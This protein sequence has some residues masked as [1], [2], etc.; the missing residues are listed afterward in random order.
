MLFSELMAAL[1]TRAIR[2]QR[3]AADL[4][5]D[6]ADDALDD[7][8][9]D[10]LAAHKPALLEMLAEQGGEWLSPALR[11]TPDMLP[12]VSLDQAAIDRIVASVPGGVA[13]VQ[14][15]YPLAPMQEGMLYHHLSAATG[16]PY[17][18]Q[19]QLRFADPARLEAFAEALDWV[20]QR[21]DIL[22]TAMRWE[23]LDAPVQVV[24]R[25]APLAR[26]CLQ[27]APGEDALACLRARFDSRHYRMDLGQAPLLRL[28]H[29]RGEGEQ[30]VALLLF[31]HTVMDHTGLDIVRREIQAHLTGEGEW[32]PAPVPFRDLLAESRMALDEQAHE[33]FFADMLAD[34]DEPTL[35]F[36]VQEVADAPVEEARLTLDPALS[37]R[38]RAQ[39]RTLGVSPASIMHLGLA[40]LLGALSG[41]DAVVF[42]SVLLGRMAAGEGGE[43]ALGMFINTLPLRVD[44]AGQGVRDGL[45]ATHRQLTAL[46]GHEQAPLALAQRCSGVTAPTPLFNSMLNYRHSA[47]GDAAEVIPVAPGIDVIGAEERTNYP[48][49]L[50]VDDL[51]EDLRLT[52]QALASWGAER[53]CAQLGQVFGELVEALEQQP[54]R[55]LL[56]LAVLTGEE[57]QHLLEAC[58]ASAVAHDLD[59]PLHALFEQQVREQGDA[60]ALSFD[61]GELSYR[62]LDQQA[63][64][65][66]HHLVGLGVGPDLR[67]A[68]CVER[69]PA[70][71]VGLLAILKAGGAYVPVDPSYPVERIRH[72]LADSAPLAVLV[73]AATRHVV[74]DGA[75]PLIDLDQPSWTTQPADAPPV[76]GLT[77]RHLAYVIYTSGSTGL[78]KGVMVE[79]RNVVNLVRWS[80]RLWPAS[81]EGALLH[82]TPIS[83]DA[84]VWELFW[85]LCSGLRLVL[86]RPDGQRDPQYLAELIQHE[87]VSV[88]QFVPALLQQFLEQPDSARCSSLTDIVCGGGELTEALARQVR[89]RLPQARLHNVYGPTETTVDCS[90]FT[91]DPQD[92]LPQG[93][94]PIGRP[95][96]NTRLYVLD[97]ADQPLPWGVAGHLHIGGAGVARGYLGLAQQQAERFIDSPFVKG[98]RLYRSGDLVRQRADGSL[99]FLGRN[100][101]QIKLRGLRIE[102]G[103]IE[104]AL[105]RVP[106]VR[107]TV[108]LVHEHA[109]SGPRLVAWYSGVAQAPEQLR[110][111][112]LAQLPEYMVPAL[113]VH[114]EV[115]PLTPN[116]KLDRKAL[117]S[118]ELPQRRHEAPQGA[119]EQALATIWSDLLGVAQVGRH[120]NFFELGGHSLLAVRLVERMRQQGLAADVR[121]LFGQPTLAALAATVGG[122]GG[123]SVPANRITAGCTHITPD[124]LP[125]AS[126]DQAAL[127]SVLAQIPGGAA[128]VQDLYA[129]APLQQGILYHHLA[130]EGADPYVVQARFA[131][132]GD[133]ELEAFVAAL[134]QVIARHDILRTSLHWQGLEE[135]VQVVWREAPLQLSP[136]LEVARL[137]LGQ[138][139]LMRLSSHREDGR[140]QATLLLHHILL[141]HTAVEQLVAEV[142]ALL[143]GERELPP[144]V[145]YR[146]YVAQA[147]LG[148]DVEADEA[149]FREL[150]GDIDEPTEVFGL[151]EAKVEAAAVRDSRLPLDSALAA[152]LRE[153]ARVLGISVASLV[154]QAWG[155]V[156]AQLSG[157]EEVVFGTV[158]LGRLQGGE[159]AD[160]ALGMFINTLPLRVSVGAAGVADGV[161]LTHQRLARLLAHEQASL[162]LAQRCSGV[163]ASQA[164]FTSLLN[165]RHSTSSDAHGPAWNGIELLAAEER[166]NYPLV[167]SVDDYGSDFRLTV[168]ATVAVEGGQV[169][170]L[171]ATALEHL[172]AALEQ[173]PAKALH[174]LSGL[175]AAE[176]ERVLQ[177]FNATARDYPRE[178][179][180]HALFEAH[181]QRAPEA[182]AVVHGQRR[183]SYAELEAQANRLAHHLIGL[184]VQPADR[185]ALLLPR[186]F[187]LLSAQLAVSKCAAVFVPL[188]ANAPAE[189]Q[190]FMVGDSQAK[191]LLTHSDQ[192]HLDGARR[193]ELDLLDLGGHAAEDLGLAVD[194]GCAAYIMYTS[195]STGTPKGVQVPHRAIVRL[196][197][198][199]GFA[200]FNSQDRV[201]FASN[202]AFDASTLEVW[203]PLLNGG[204]VVVIDQDQVLSRQALREVLLAQGVTVLWLTAGLF[205]QFADDLLPAFR[206]LRYLMVGG[207]VLDP[208]VIARVLRNGAPQH[209]LNGYGPTEATTFSTTHEITQVGEG[210]IPIGRPIGNGR[211]YVLDARQQLLPVGAVGELYIAGDGVALGYLGQPELTAER[212]LADPFNGGTMYRS[213][214]LVCWQADGTL[215]YLGRADQQIKLRGFRIELGEI[216]ARLGECAGV[217]DTAVVVREDAPGDKRLVAYFTTNGV[218]PAIAELH[219]RLQGQLPDYMLPAAYVQLEALPLTAN[220]KLDRRALPQPGSDAV[221]SRTFEAP[222]G[223]IEVA[224]AALWAEVLKVEQVGRHDHFFELGGHSLLA[225][226]LIERMRKAGLNADV[227]VLFAQPTLAALAAAVG[228]G[229]EIEVPANRVPGNAT[230]ITPDMLSLIALDQASIDRIVATVPGGAANVQEIYPLAPLQQGILYHHLSADEGDPYLLQSRLAFDSLERL[231]AWAGALQ[232]V[233]DRHDILRTAVLWEGL[234]EP[235]QVVW[236]QARLSLSEVADLGEDAVLERLQARFDARHQ[237]LDLTQAPLLRLV[238]ARDPRQGEYVALLQ[239]HHLTL[240]HAAMAVIGEEMQALLDGHAAQLPAAVPYRNYVAQVCLGDAQAAHE[241]FFRQQLGDVEAPTLPYGLA[242]VQGDGG[243]LDQAEQHLPGELA[244]AVREQAR[245]RG[246]SAASLMHLAWARVVGV[247]AGR[248]DV[249]FGTVLMGRLQGGEGADRALGMFINTLPLRVDVALPVAQA[250]Q[251]TH[252]RLSALLGHEHAPLALAQRCSGVASTA[253]LFSALLNY[254]HSAGPA[255]R[256]GE[257]IWQGVRLLGGEERSN[258]PLTLSVDDLGEG[259]SLSVLAVEGIQAGQV[260]QWMVAAL[261]QLLHSLE[262]APEQAFD[263]APLLDEVSARQVLVDF[264]ATAVHYPK[265]QTVQAMVEAQAPEALAVVQG[266]QRL[267]YGELN[268]RANR[269]AHY[270]IRRGVACG[271]RVALCLERGPQRLVGMLAVLKAGA[272]YVPVDPAYPAQRIA[273]LL[274][275]SAPALVLVEAATAG[276]VG[277]VASVAL[278]GDAWRGEPDTNPVVEGLD[279]Q[280]LAYVIYTSGSTGQPKGVMVEHHTLANLVHWHGAAF[281]LG[282]GAHTSSVAGFGFDAM[283]WE[284]WP[285]LC[286]GATLHLPPAAIAGEHVDEL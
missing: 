218:A 170:Q 286:V 52:V 203:A 279:D 14:D 109:Q 50:A 86:A 83:F 59:T 18:L 2:L 168:Q 207:D 206:R 92:P 192:P 54:E 34:I 74:Q 44:L 51:G 153:Q 36:G 281:E 19:A 189:R 60:I 53:L 10:A 96:D 247:L 250:L 244:R 129:L 210:S 229:R 4:I 209:L 91:L 264:N 188:D 261:A 177:Q 240:D 183:W 105:D 154:H 194:A 68:V 89:E 278:D 131:F 238:Y 126:L 21:H 267:S 32:L 274:S 205:H 173:A 108:V 146:N 252:Q 204:A 45:L 85:P 128:N 57:R 185:V 179:P 3:E 260:A 73:H 258:Y 79:H 246:V 255:A 196:A 266:E 221:V 114:L 121:V 197:I 228:S 219:E 237:R 90:V 265:G 178:L 141:D 47:A 35:A 58:N 212:F 231:Q 43:Q 259:F 165:Y 17:V 176:R 61:G 25:H 284:A 251:L 69:G 187:D 282:A 142:G 239:F 41:R 70:M 271:D 64:R 201:A 174:S 242:D 87:R 172:V 223:A 169:C 241:A 243:R 6:G 147:R 122:A 226:S 29:A 157:R 269:L 158:L 16:D 270:L 81:A 1:S 123:V 134:N 262:Q 214:D 118:P 268:Q 216:E 133:A 20:I 124:L 38:L 104:A 143:R 84:S 235:V 15:I 12:L 22:R 110:E 11:I 112:L 65:L 82:K 193:V 144:S 132:A 97:S 166:S 257:G 66:A 88:V 199:N 263:H 127:D 191:V 120:D 254:R 77:P 182:L 227:R 164:L 236:R 115:M 211:C 273:Y 28:V 62:Q 117:P 256:D 171:L 222:Q 23:R 275:D 39:A 30:V 137:D 149:L 163:P 253:P 234:A 215:R 95:I 155:Q 220:G 130:S 102:P 75:A 280:Q 106:G 33:A 151:R 55:P 217:R 160:R 78:P 101:H 225:V 46:L 99:E 208:A 119:T 230:H 116:G 135:A 181:A 94:L 67:V 71:L 48:L 272:A 7:A 148:A 198:N 283:A 37:R 245:Q 161:R 56:Q 139:P 63:N 40:R 136:A 213:G 202:P 31:H 42:G 285:A 113:F 8:L 175:P 93:A 111:R 9:W 152:R 159:G 162:A 200:D 156:L 80:A 186:S 27:P 138:A 195:G 248:H 276:L 26:E 180:L 233:I 24:W 72:M 190:A 150:L 140:L 224:L 167:V 49:S 232:Q 100:D 277:E 76:A 103:E 13:N 249:V 184:G 107:E 145:P 125:L 5:V 98:E